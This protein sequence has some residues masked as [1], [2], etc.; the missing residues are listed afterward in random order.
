MAQDAESSEIPTEPPEMAGGFG[1]LARVGVLGANAWI[2]I[3]FIPFMWFGTRYPAAW[4]AAAAAPIMLAGGLLALKRSQ[5]VARWV[6]LAGVPAGL[7]A[8]ASTVPAWPPVAAEHAAVVALAAA[9]LL[10][11]GTVTARACSM[12]VGSRPSVAAP[13]REARDPGPEAHR[14]ARWRG[15]MLVG[16]GIG[17]F[18]LTVVAPAWVDPAVLRRD[19]GRAAA[20]AAVLTAVAAGVLAMVVMTLFVAPALRRRR[21]PL[22]PPGPLALRVTLLLLLA[23]MGAYVLQLA[24]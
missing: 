5:R 3:F 20:E 18:A 24:R 11:Y 14:R 6:L 10:A 1:D 2:V 15:A 9:S 22:R 19:W 7:A 8:A 16:T 12:P 17:A 13:L 21:R 23:A 4:G